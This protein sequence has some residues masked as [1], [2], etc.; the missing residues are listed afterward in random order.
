MKHLITN[1]DLNVLCT[2]ATTMY[3]D[4]VV[5]IHHYLLIMDDV[6]GPGESLFCDDGG[7]EM[8]KDKTVIHVE[9]KE[10][11][12]TTTWT[13]TKCGNLQFVRKNKLCK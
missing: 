6:E 7:A 5:N 8:E 11:K 2:K 13:Q 9:G 10:E 12:R 4:Y 3:N 1:D